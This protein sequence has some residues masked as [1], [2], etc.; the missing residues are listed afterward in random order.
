[1]ALSPE[2]R[3][4]MA[5]NL[6]DDMPSVVALSF[7]RV[8]TTIFGFIEPAQAIAFARDGLN[9]CVPNSGLSVSIVNLTTKRIVSKILPRSN[10]ETA[11]FLQQKEKSNDFRRIVEAESGARARSHFIVRKT[12]SGYNAISSAPEPERTGTD[13]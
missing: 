5:G 3:S 7:F 11:V 1:V 6:T 12:G 2:E 13:R 4:L 10:V 8:I 9:G